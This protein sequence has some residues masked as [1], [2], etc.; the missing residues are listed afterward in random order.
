MNSIVKILFSIIILATSINSTAQTDT[1]MLKNKDKIIGEIK[2]MKKGV[3]TIETDYSDSDFKISW[4]EVLSMSSSQLYFIT[5]TKG[6]RLQS[7]IKAKPE[8]P[9]AIFLSNG[10][11]WIS[12][13]IKDV[14]EFKAVESNILSRITTSVSLGYNFTKS[15]NLSQFILNGKLSY[16]GFKW[17]SNANYDAIVSTQDQTN[18]SERTDAGLGFRYFMQRDWF[19]DVTASFL[20]NNQLDLDLRSNVRGGAGKFL[21]HNNKLYLGIGAG[22]AWNN[23]KYITV[24]E[25]NRT[26][27]E[28]YG[29]LEFNMF[30]MG[31]LDVYTRILFYP[32]LTESGRVR[33]D[34]DFDLK[35]DLPLDL[36]IKLGFTYNYDNKP[37][38]GFNKSDYVFN[39]TFGWEFN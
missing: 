8:S 30:D 18:R 12:I 20:S 17:E 10:S 9:N 4:L 3:L 35:Y 19:L 15:N 21:L 37:A 26:S 22:L 5:L 32:S 27:A 11:E 38:A 28:S 25:D 7:H 6:Q 24:P 2:H 13:P 34:I 36:F 23:E 14:V 1:L 16:T 33:S 39:T 31:D 29:G